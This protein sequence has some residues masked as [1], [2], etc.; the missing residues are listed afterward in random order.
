MALAGKRDNPTIV[1]AGLVPAIHDFL[2]AIGRDFR[3]Q[4]IRG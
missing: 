2:P 1:M 3:R 4:E